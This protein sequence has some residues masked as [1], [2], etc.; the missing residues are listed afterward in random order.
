MDTAKEKIL[1]IGGGFSGMVAAI[2]LKRRGFDVELIERSSE[3]RADGAGI[4][5]GGSTMRLFDQL[6][7]MDDF[8]QIGAAHEGIE[9]RNGEDEVIVSLP[10]PGLAPGAPGIGGAMRPALAK[11]L[12]DKVL[13]EGVKVR[14]GATWTELDAET[15]HV[16][17]SD[18]S[19]G[20]YDVIVGADGLWSKTRDHIFPNAPRAAYLGQQIWRAVIDRPSKLPTLSMWM[21]QG[22]KAGINHVSDKRSYLFLTEDRPENGPP[23]PEKFVEDLK[24][25]L[26]KIPSP[27]LAE[28]AGALDDGSMIDIRP[29]EKLILPLPWGVGRVVLMGDSVHATTPH[30]ASGALIGM[31]DGV[32]LSEE[33]DKPGPL[34]QRLAAFGE[35]RFERCR[36]VVENS[37]RLAEIEVT[38]GDRAEHATIMKES[39]MALAQPF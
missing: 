4:S 20:I 3:W 18:G 7:L 19:E 35:R 24:G 8:R 13:A 28:V 37:G 15:G 22:L 5:L 23:R 32:V 26:A 25:L 36:M 38:N 33:L 30:L 17:F 1:I 14:L 27:T 21:G 12:A 9:I 29:A 11:M 34:D 16:A 31:E 10:T 39:G 2:S 6:G